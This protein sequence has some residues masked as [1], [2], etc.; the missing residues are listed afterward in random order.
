MNKEKIRAVVIGHAIGDAL[1]V[2]V[3][4]ASREELAEEPV[5]GM[6]A[7]GTYGMPAG[8]WSDDTSMSLCALAALG[9]KDWTFTDVMD[10]FAAWM[11]KGAF[12]ATDDAFDIGNTCFNAIL[13]YVQGHKEAESCGF[14]SELDNGN[15]S[16]MRIH[17]FALLAYGQPDAYP[18]WEQLID[19][20]SALTHAH[21]R[22]QLACKLYTLILMAL[23]DNPDKSSVL[24]ALIQAACRYTDHP[25]Y[26]H[27][28]RLL[29]LRFPT[30]LAEEI[31]SS[32]Y[33]VD[34]LE[35]AVWCLLT[36]D[37]YEECVLK[38]VNLGEDTD[39]V[40]AVAGGLAG[41]LY[42]YDAI[43]A[44]WRDTLVQREYIE[45]LCDA[46]CRAQSRE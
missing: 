31:R 44:P 17:P 39:T 41:A 25:E 4:F 38:A 12:S 24:V 42:G 28:A 27:F 8:T 1:G 2:P 26:R 5:T 33:V 23:L 34:T 35:A 10:N 6:M 21:P 40:A 15:G 20:A 32:G 30:L 16:L 43:P 11:T 36:T 13:D 22:S 18:D 29:S 7:G 9:K 37:S 3:E 19:R 46:F 45:E 14:D